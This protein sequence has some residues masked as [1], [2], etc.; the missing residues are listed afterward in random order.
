MFWWNDRS[1]SIFSENYF[2][3]DVTPRL[4][5]IQAENYDFFYAFTLLDETSRLKTSMGHFD[6]SQHG[7][8][9]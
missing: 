1:M 6:I 9:E 4:A 2:V 8:W 7:S 5:L 3:F